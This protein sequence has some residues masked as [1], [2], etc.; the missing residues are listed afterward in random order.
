MV[1]RLKFD[2]VFWSTETNRRLRKPDNNLQYITYIAY[3][4]LH[5]FQRRKKILRSYVGRTWVAAAALSVGYSRYYVSSEAI[6]KYNA[7]SLRH[8]GFPP[9]LLAVCRVPIK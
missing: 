9:A 1:I 6:H 4:A 5:N 3:L 7:F 8:I 2:P